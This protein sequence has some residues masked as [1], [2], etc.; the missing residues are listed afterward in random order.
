MN[1]REA[2]ELWIEANPH[3]RVLPDHARSRLVGRVW[4]MH[5]ASLDG[6]PLGLIDDRT[7]RYLKEPE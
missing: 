5:S 6:T 3:A 4:H 2:V 1:Y 7:G